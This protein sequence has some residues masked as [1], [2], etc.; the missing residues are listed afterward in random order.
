MVLLLNTGE[1][2]K[3]GFFTET[4][5]PIKS[6]VVT[7]IIN[8][9]KELERQGHKVYVFTPKYPGYKDVDKNIIRLNAIRIPNMTYAITL[10]IKSRVW[11]LCKNL[12]I[13]HVHHPV[14]IGRLALYIARAYNKPLIFT[15]HSNYE[16][17]SV[18]INL[19]KSVSKKL[20]RLYIKSFLELCDYIIVPSKKMFDFFKKLNLTKPIELIPTGINIKDFNSKISDK[21]AL[22]VRRELD[23]DNNKIILLYIGRLAKEKNVKLLI[24]LMKSMR[25]SMAKK[26]LLVIIG[27]GPEKEFLE[28]EIAL[29]KLSSRIKMLGGFVDYKKLIPYYKAADIFITPSKQESQG[30]T[31]L[32]SMASGTPVVAIKNLGSSTL[33]KSYNN[34][35]LARN[36]F[37]FMRMV[38]RLVNDKKLRIKLSNKA[39]E[40][41]KEYSIKDCTKKLLK[42]YE[43]AIKNKKIM[44]REKKKK[45]KSI[46]SNIKEFLPVELVSEL[47][48]NKK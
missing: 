42:V 33:I 14:Y 41:V 38:K 27:E 6:G 46:T 5:K 18:Y 40:T 28:E 12:D 16:D 23:P 47:L 48:E 2:V 20:I 8:F 7:S 9:K 3:I 11:K 17:Y 30:L 31:L 24:R 29:N 22:L 35:L 32:E 15:A 13:I 25:A 19:S 36:D 43:E 44:I 34:G 21:K 45:F 39:L 10:P 26:V 37:E 4:Y 1:I